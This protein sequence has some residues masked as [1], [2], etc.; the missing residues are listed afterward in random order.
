MVTTTGDAE[1]AVAALLERQFGLRPSIFVDAATQVRALSLFLERRAAYTA[2]QRQALAHGLAGIKR[3][4]LATHPARIRFRRLAAENWAESWKRHFK[5]I[6]VSP[7]LLIKPSWSR[8]RPRRGQVVVTLD[9]GLSFG[10]G[11]HPT[12]AFCL[13]QLVAGR[14]SEQSLSFLDIGTGS[15]ILA[16]A[17]AKLG[18]GPVHGFDADP[19]AIG[20]ARRNA[21]SN[22]VSGLVHFE[23]RDLACWPARGRR[24]DVIGANLTDDLLLAC[25][26]RILSRL[27]AQGRLVLAGILGRRFE[28]VRRHYTTAGLRLVASERVGEWRSGAFVFR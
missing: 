22:R 11:Q 18:Y 14:H 3:S 17:A 8:R 10:T 9:P 15:G 12:T 7:A 5:P 19:E 1:A 27:P 13:R 26:G 20:V 21:K 16:I 28:T 2:A 6:E 24:Y 23:T 4:G 25:S